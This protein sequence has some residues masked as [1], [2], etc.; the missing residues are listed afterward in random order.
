MKPKAADTA[1]AAP[2]RSSRW[3]IGRVALAVFVAALLIRVAF[4]GATLASNT[5]SDVRGFNGDTLE[6]LWLAEGWRQRGGY[7][8]PDDPANAQS[9]KARSVSLV[10]T[11]LYPAMVAG[12]L[13]IEN[14]VGLRPEGYDDAGDKPRVSRG[15]GGLFAY[16][17]LFGVQELMDAALAAL[18]ALLAGRLWRS[19]VAAAVAGGAMAV[20]PS[21]WS[22]AA[23]LLTDHPFAFLSGA[24]LWLTIKAARPSTPRRGLLS[25]ALAGV[26][27]ALAILMKPTLLFWP[28]ALPIVWLVARGP[29]LVSLPRGGAEWGRLALVVLPLVLTIVGWVAHNKAVHGVTAF[30]AVPERNLMMMIAPVVELRAEEAAGGAPATRDRI[31]DLYEEVKD[32]NGEF[33]AD[34]DATVASVVQRRR[35][36]ASERIA[37]HKRIAAGVYVDNLVENVLSGW[38]SFDRQLPS[39]TRAMRRTGVDVPMGE[40]APAGEPRTL[41]TRLA[42]VAF[43]PATFLEDLW[44]VRLLIWLAGLGGFVLALFRRDARGP[45]LACAAFIAYLL[46]T[47]ATTYGQGSRILYPAF[48][49][50]YALAAGLLTLVPRWRA[51]G[52]SSTAD[53]PA[54]R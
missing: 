45:A 35:D 16:G 18:A 19:P 49:P 50:L 27:W 26:L 42:R 41:L 9:L 1:E 34:P 2:R 32:I 10:R 25:A 20:S 47:G 28:I 39:R 11:P 44:P 48:A 17:L 12:A 23:V 54:D 46:L 24:A 33:L 38:T 51:T 30:S 15:P 52:V 40:S 31:R 7:V 5:P 29:R 3:T 53:A 4:V 22:G 13:A 14:A 37:P 21:G 8:P 43:W 36:Y 6:Y